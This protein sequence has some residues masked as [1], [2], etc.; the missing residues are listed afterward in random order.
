MRE[1]I[2]HSVPNGSLA[3]RNNSELYMFY[4]S[5]F[6]Q[7]NVYYLSELNTYIV[8]EFENNSADIYDLF[9]YSKVSLND[10]C[11]CLGRE[12]KEVRLLFTPNE[13]D[14][15]ICDFINEDDTTLFIK[16]QIEDDLRDCK[17]MFP[18]L[19]HA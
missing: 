7:E 13:T 1:I 11:K 15:L 18:A 14:G 4:L 19:S 10:V 12:I 6:M 17:C 9:S 5:Q 8:A 3:M 16:G 2:E